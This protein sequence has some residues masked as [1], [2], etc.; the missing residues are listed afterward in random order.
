MTSD[1]KVINF[2]RVSHLEMTLSAYLSPCDFYAGFGCSDLGSSCDP[3]DNCG[4]RIWC[5]DVISD[6]APTEYR[7]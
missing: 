7:P 6:D 1:V 2:G 3:T 4:I 5:A